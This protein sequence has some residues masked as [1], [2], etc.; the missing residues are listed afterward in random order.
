[1]TH[2]KAWTQKS[3]LSTFRLSIAADFVLAISP[4]IEMA[5]LDKH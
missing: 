1:M 3:Q 5:G 4:P 2:V